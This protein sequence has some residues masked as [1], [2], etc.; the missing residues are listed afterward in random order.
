MGLNPSKIYTKKNGVE[1]EVPSLY[2]KPNSGMIYAV[3]MHHVQS[4]ARQLAIVNEVLP[5]D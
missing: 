1:E 4:L 2:T 3:P 5:Q